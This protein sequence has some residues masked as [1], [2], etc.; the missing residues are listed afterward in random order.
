MTDCADWYKAGYKDSGVY[1]ISLN[2]TSHNVYC[3]MDNGGG[4]TVFQNRVNNNG[5]FWDRS[6]DDYKN[7]FNTER[8]TNVSNFWLGLE[9]LHQLTE[10]DKD[11][12]LRVEM[13]GD[14]TPGSSKALSSW[15][16]EYTRFKVAGKSSKFQLTDLYLDNQGKGT[17]IWNSLIYSVGANFSAVDH[18]NDP[19]SNCVWQYK[20]GGWWLRNCALSSLN[21]DYDFTEANGYGMFWIIGGTDNIIH[22]VSTR[23]MLRPTSFST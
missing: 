9:L 10:K 2:G 5:S 1:S 7:G 6:W 11:V 20:M 14:R 4:W 22:P 19:Q 17:S 16:N 21:G 23:M 3:S 8:M 15:S 13:M 18:I 12:T